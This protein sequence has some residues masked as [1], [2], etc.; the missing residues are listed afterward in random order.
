MKKFLI[1]TLLILFSTIGLFAQLSSIP[2][3]TFFPARGDEGSGSINVS[4]YVIDATGE[5]A[6]FI[7][8]A[9]KTGNITKFETNV[10]TVT[11]APD[12]GLRLSFQ[13]V[14]TT[15]GQPDGTV[16][17]FVKTLGGTPSS[18]GWLNAGNFDNS[19]AVTKG[20]IFACVIDIETFTTG[21][22]LAIGGI[23]SS[24][25]SGFP[26]GISAST[27]K[28][29]T[30]LLIIVLAYDD[31]TYEIVEAEVWP[32][33]TVNAVS[34]DTADSPD[35]VGL[36]FEFPFPV[37]LNGLAAFLR[38]TTG[39]GGNSYSFILYDESDNVLESLLVDSDINGNPAGLFLQTYIFDTA[40]NLD[41]NTIYRLTAR[42]ESATIVIQTWYNTYNSLELMNAVFNNSS[43]TQRTNAGSWTNFD[44]GTDGY[45]LPRF[46][47]LLSGFNT[48]SS[49]GG[50]SVPFIGL[51]LI[52]SILA[53]TRFS[54]SLR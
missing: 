13:D 26:Y 48:G 1:T 50:S 16:D 35:E 29:T 25:D 42:A 2:Y 22:S 21:D 36:V 33:S 47:L 8:Q 34:Y 31:G 7:I 46:H 6:A 51:F 44:N 39:T 4:T 19:R 9:P 37:T 12:D 5:K 17:Q 43:M 41:A 32:I 38:P 20:D 49:S 23:T 52:S 54:K 10:V 28:N 14:N 27:T 53:Y 40:I 3:G 18:S 45:R 30:V 11:N 24:S 15:T